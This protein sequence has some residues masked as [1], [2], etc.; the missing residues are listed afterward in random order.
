M[1]RLISILALL[2]LATAAVAQETPAPVPENQALIDAAREAKAKRKASKSR[3]ITNADVKKSTGRL[4]ELSTPKSS[5][6]A[7]KTPPGPGPIAQHD[8]F[9]KARAAARAKVSAAEG[10]LMAAEADLSRAEQSYFD[11][12][13]PNYRDQVITKRFEAAR[14]A[15]DKARENLD[16][17]KKALEPYEAPADSGAVVIDKPDTH[18]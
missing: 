15:R 1:T 7:T 12:N 17:E 9:L 4:I 13:D 3:V 10:A 2:F 11:V 14:I 5:A 6:P 16:A 8:A 18:E